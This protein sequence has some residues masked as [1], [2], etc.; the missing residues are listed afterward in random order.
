[1]GLI[2]QS[3]ADYNLVRD[4]LGFPIQELPDS[5]VTEAEFLGAAEAWVMER[6]PDW[7][8]ILALTA[9]TAPALAAVA[10]TA[11]TLAAATYSAALVARVG[12]TTSP[13]GV[14]ATQVIAAGQALAV[15]APA[16]PGITAYDGYVGVVGVVAGQ[17]FRQAQLVGMQPGATVNLEAFS[18]SGQ[19]SGALQNP[20]TV[21][22]AATAALCC[23]FICRRFQRAAPKT[24]KT[25]TYEEQF[26]HDW[27]E[28]A[29]KYLADANRYLG[30][31]PTYNLV[32]TP[33]L[34]LAHPAPAPY[35][36]NYVPGSN[37]LA[38][39]RETP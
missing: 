36:P 2:L 38:I 26:D 35:S 10:D 12:D 5:L 21:L 32:T 14:T 13:L 39:P 11:S 9:P 37:P 20:P 24:L 22:R 25:Q 28:E 34:Q 16:A 27:R 19:A 15:T 6:V 30:M 3:T 29:A 4:Q 31:L 33:A 7:Q 1:M 17:L 18:L 8:L 23:S